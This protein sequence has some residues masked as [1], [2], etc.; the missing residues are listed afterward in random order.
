LPK[1]A[2]G[3]LPIECSVEP[4]VIIMVVPF[5]KFVVE[6]VNIIANT[7]LVEE[8]VKL[9]FVDAVRTFDLAV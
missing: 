4:V 9:L 8:L 1:A 5:A 2:R 6:H 3:G 7:V